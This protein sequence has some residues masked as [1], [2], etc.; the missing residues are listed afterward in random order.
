MSDTRVLHFMDNSPRTM[1]LGTE[2]E[3]PAVAVLQREGSQSPYHV[4][5]DLIYPRCFQLLYCRDW[6]IS[7]GV[8]QSPFHA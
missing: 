6:A 5:G 2:Q 3:D 1:L 7:L 4:L 8:K